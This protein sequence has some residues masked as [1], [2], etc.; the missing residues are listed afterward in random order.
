MSEVACIRQWA[1][2]MEESRYSD[3]GQNADELNVY[4]VG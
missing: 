4:P 2:Q 3:C 1:I